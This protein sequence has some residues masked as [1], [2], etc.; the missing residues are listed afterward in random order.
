MHN[1]LLRASYLFLI[2]F[3]T[4]RS[5]TTLASIPSV[6]PGLPKVL[7]EENRNQ[8]PSQVRYMADL[9]NGRVFFE[10]NAFTYVFF[11]DLER[12]HHSATR[13]TDR[14]KHHAFKVRFLNAESSPTISGKDIYPFHRNYFIGQNRSRWAEGVQVYNGIQYSS[15]YPGIDLSVY[16]HQG[17]FKYDFI[18]QPGVSP[19]WI[20][21]KYDGQDGLT[22]RDGHLFIQTSVGE[23]QEQEPYAYQVING[24]KVKVA[25]AY[26]LDEQNVLGFRISGPYDLNEPLVI[27]PTLIV[28]TY[29]GST[30]DNFGY[31]ATYD[32]TGNIYTGGIAFGAGYPTVVGSY[33]VSYNGGYDASITKFNTTGTALLFSTY[34]GGFSNDQPHSMIVN[35]SNQLYVVGRTNSSDF[36][37]LGAYDGVWEF[38]YDMFIGRF[39]STG[40]L[41]SSTFVGGD[42]DDG[43]NYSASTA[44]YGSTKYNYADDG[45][46]EIMLDASSNVYV[47]MCTQST[48][49]FASSPYDN[50]IN[51]VQDAVVFKMNN[52]LSSLTWGT[53]LG[54]SSYDAAYGIKVDG[55]NNVYVTGGTSSADFPTSAGVLNTAFLGGTAD[56]FITVFTSAGAFSRST[57]I[58]TA[59]YDQCFFI[60]LDAS[61][62]V[63]VMGQT[64]GAYT[65]TGGTYSNA[66][67]KQFLHKLN[68][69]LTGTSFSTVFG[70]NV[71][72]PNISPT[73]FLVDSCQ[74]LYVSGWGRCGGFFMPNTSS[75]TGMPITGNAYQSTTDGCDFYFIVLTANAQSLWYSTFFGRNGGTGDHVD[76]GTSRFDRRAVI[77]QSVCAGCGGSSAFPT[78][79]GAYSNVNGSFNC[80]NAVI[81]MDVKVKAIAVASANPAALIGCAPYLVNFFSTGSTASS[82]QWD[83]G[84]GSPL[85]SSA[86]PTHTYTASGTY[87]VSFVATL[88]NGIC[89]FTDTKT[90]VVTVGSSSNITPSQSNVSCFGTATGSATVTPT[91]GLNPYTY[92]WSPGGQTSSSVTGLTAGNY[93]VTVYDNV[94]CSSTGTI[95]ITQPTALNTTSVSSTPKA[96]TTNNGTATVYPS[97]GTPN[98]TY[99][100][101]P[102]GQTTSTATGLNSGT[103]TVTV[104]DSRGC[105]ST[106][107]VTVSVAASPTV[108]AGSTVASCSLTNGTATASTS[109]GSP[110]YTYAWQP[111]GQTTSVATGLAG[112][113]YTITVTDIN[114]CTGTRTVTV[115]STSS[116]TITATPTQPAGCTFAVGSAS[117]T[118]T[119]GTPNFTY[120]WTPS[121]QT[122]ANATGLGAG[123]HTVIITDQNGCKDTTTVSIT[124][125]TPPSVSATATQQTGCLVSIGSASA[126]PTGGTPGYSYS[127]L[128]GGQTT[129]T[130]TGLGAGTYSVILTDANGCKDTAATTITTSN[131]PSTTSSVN[132]NVSCFGGSN[133]T[134][135]TTPSGGTPNYTYIW[136]PGGQTTSSA[137]G[138]TAGN[139]TVVVSDANGCTFTDQVTIT[140][141][142]LLGQTP[143]QTNVNCFGNSNSTASVTANGG[144]PGYTYS[145]SNGQSTSAATGLAAGNY[146]VVISDANGC[147]TT[148]TFAITQPTALASVPSQTNILCNTG[149]NGSATVTVSG[150]TPGYTYNWSNGGSTSAI[151]NIAAGNYSVT[152]TDANGCTATNSFTITQPVTLNLASAQTNILC[153][154]G[155]N[156]N[157][158]VNPSGGTPNY[159]FVWGGGQ[160]TSAISGLTAGNYAVIVSDANGCTNTATFTITQ[161]PVLSSTV[162]SATITCNGGNNGSAT[163]SPAGGTPGYSYVWNNG[164]TNATATNLIAGNYS[165]SI[166]DANGCTA[167]QSV[168]I[169]QPPPITLTVSG[170]DSLCAGDSAVLVAAS[171]GGTPAYT[172]I[173][174][175]G[176]NSGSAITVNPTSN[177]SYTVTMTDANGCVSLAQ[178]FNVAMLPNP[179]ALFDTASNG[180]FSS[181]YFFGDLS[182]NGTNWNWIFGDGGT[183]VAQNPI[184]T[185]PGAGTYTV[186]QIVTNS[187][188]CVDTFQMLLII[189]ENI[190]IPNVFTPNGDGS[191]DVWYIPNSGMKEFHVA[192]FD[193]WGLKVFETTADEIRWDG[194]TSSGVMLTD[195]T[196]YF[197]LDAYLRTSTNGVKHI[198]Y[199][200]WITL[201]TNNR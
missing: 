157:A 119:G 14:V 138:L 10:N 12:F 180:L 19:S 58:G 144:T 113:N 95:N 133:G 169:S 173:W 193:R 167:T 117:A 182:T 57:F 83:F 53:Y 69:A 124:V 196:Y 174:L 6:N 75:T 25:C 68:N 104:T 8:W 166:T 149:T 84:D 76:G 121:G 139:Y 116:P 179:T 143:A 51:G 156:G 110:A 65:V 82:Y 115:N 26:T 33:D 187:F 197:V 127:W 161:P 186:T 45:R 142:T 103:H 43:V 183:S 114:G 141:P 151:T 99:S 189:P 2:L 158:S 155:N 70:T 137:T 74:N 165:V 160:T 40:G 120:A 130:A 185:F 201:L 192:I 67:G 28:S 35:S 147:T 135:S 128:P 30:T 78:S 96:C 94:G 5:G 150:G 199:K 195:G 159:T 36:P 3:L 50:A 11:E 132:A 198:E 170:I 102:T 129:Q 134:A 145:W 79:P 154:G 106:R 29:T 16:Q 42:G 61:N 41:L 64:E 81:K 200:G 63:Y 111:G 172:Y 59:S 87:T 98:Y 9:P 101:N 13:E 184:H 32:A 37:V 60:E 136:Q 73:A 52:I 1:S 47:A 90:L 34:F 48:N 17:S 85:S 15:L 125:S 97:G 27:D 21:M 122:S 152:I 131:G 109:G 100:W 77:Y 162:N 46:G 56:G 7:F 39:N 22:V 175:P 171:S 108:T 112:G 91:G 93:T 178:T 4:F 177:A 176:P 72:Y 190:L 44:T 191:N 163:V 62:A 71:L 49:L 54:G 118:P 126:T 140:Q 153:N 86:N 38:G 105:A 92:A 194:R 168:S 80:N 24:V 55:S 20:R 146:S 148:Q 89:N 88:T 31:T 107:T 18:V 164:Q 66:G 188:G 123:T 181:V 23:I